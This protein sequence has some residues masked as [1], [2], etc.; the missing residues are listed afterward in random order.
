MTC[1]WCERADVELPWCPV[2]VFGHVV[3]AIRGRMA[4]R[5]CDRC[6]TAMTLEFLLDD[7][8]GWQAIV[9]LWPIHRVV[10]PRREDVRLD[11]DLL[12]PDENPEDECVR[13]EF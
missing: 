12:D 3:P 1:W 8:G 4:L 5:V 9:E 7:G 2:L 6:R 11:F 10:A 13:L